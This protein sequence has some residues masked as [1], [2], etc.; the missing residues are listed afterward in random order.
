MSTGLLLGS[1]EAARVAAALP[2][3]SETNYQVPYPNKLELIGAMSV[4]STIEPV[5]TPEEI[6]EHRVTDAGI[7]TGKLVIPRLTVGNCG[8]LLV[9][10]FD[11]AVIETIANGELD[12]DEL[13]LP[14]LEGVVDG[15]IAMED[16][17]YD[18][19]GADA[20]VEFRAAGQNFK[21]RS[22]FTQKLKNGLVVPSYFGDGVNSRDETQ[23]TPDPRRLIAARVQ[24]L[25]LRQ[26]MQERGR[27]PIFAHEALS[28]PYEHM[29]T[30]AHGKE[31]YIRSAHRLW[32]GD[33][34]NDP[35]GLHVALLRRVANPYGIKIGP[36]SGREHIARLA[37]QLN[38]NEPG[39]VSFMIRI[40]LEDR[41]KM[42]EVAEAIAEF[43][44]G[45]LHQMDTH[46]VTVD[47]RYDD[48]DP[49][50][51]RSVERI[52]ATT[53]ATRDALRNAGLV[54]HGLHLEAKAS[55]AN[56]ECVDRDGEIP[57]KENKPIVDP[58][59]TLGQLRAVLRKT[60]E[61]LPGA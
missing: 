48:G 49:V 52:V 44:P 7:A 2:D 21:P 60:R 15:Y 51:I 4:L 5:A 28:L 47:W 56:P 8:E 33:R 12:I 38:L 34:T 31:R 9:S 61:Y 27:S 25:K 39:R 45:Q 20:S 41:D 59:L 1:P 16:V 50:K 46:G 36:K 6:R 32:V 26:L 13:E 19:F 18:E 37:E 53:K 55:D 29:A 23:R 57:D 17:A 22:S 30:Y 3:P 14:S 54:L 10:D 58:L 24:S 40:P 35:D 43:A 42:E 11:I